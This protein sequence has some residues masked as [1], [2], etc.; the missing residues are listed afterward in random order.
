MNVFSYKQ[1]KIKVV[2]SIWFVFTVLGFTTVSCIV[3]VNLIRFL[4]GDIQSLNIAISS[5][6]LFLPVFVI[7]TIFVYHKIPYFEIQ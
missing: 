3:A 5:V 4:E 7:F 2:V 1:L 6:L